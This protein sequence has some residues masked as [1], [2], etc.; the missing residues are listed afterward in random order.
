MPDDLQ[1]ARLEREIVNCQA[2]L[3]EAWK[4]GNTE[5]ARIEVVRLTDLVSQRSEAQ[6]ARMEREMGLQ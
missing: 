3:D 4:S 6:I 5:I 2:R 1:D